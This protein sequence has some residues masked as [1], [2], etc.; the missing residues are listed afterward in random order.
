MTIETLWTI[1]A[2]D[3][4]KSL[5]LGNMFTVM[6]GILSPLARFLVQQPIG[7]EGKVAAACFNYYDFGKKPALPQLLAEMQTAI[8]AYLD[9]TE[10]TPD[11]VVV[12]NYGAQ[13]QA[14]LGVQ[15]TM[16]SL[17]DLTSFKKVASPVVKKSSPGV[18]NRGAK[19]FGSV[20]L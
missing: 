20:V 3:A 12:D 18:S 4:R 17:L 15:N 1:E 2:D 16:A 9:V 7:D 19:G 11:Q 6:L 5:I 13:I 10:E 8:D 14:L